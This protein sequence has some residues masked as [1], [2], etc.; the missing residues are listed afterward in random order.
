MFWVY[1][2]KERDLQETTE[3]TW[4]FEAEYSSLVPNELSYISASNF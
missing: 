2:C 4:G 3:E 1:N